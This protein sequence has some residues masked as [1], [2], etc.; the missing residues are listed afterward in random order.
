MKKNNYLNFHETF[1]NITLCPHEAQDF[2]LISF[3]FFWLEN[4]YILTYLDVFCRKVFLIKKWDFI[5]KYSY[6]SSNLGYLFYDLSLYLSLMTFII[7][8][9]VALTAKNICIMICCCTCHWWLS[10]Y[11]LLHSLQTT[12]VLWYVAFIAN[13]TRFMICCWTCHWCHS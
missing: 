7:W 10:Y 3:T 9:V 2:L 13:S 5:R 8:F 4:L 11:D 6:F 1:W 12:F